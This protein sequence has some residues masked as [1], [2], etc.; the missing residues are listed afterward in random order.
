MALLL[1]HQYDALWSYSFGGLRSKVDL[2]MQ[3]V[4][5]LRL[6]LSL[7]LERER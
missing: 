3:I 2:Q 1:W 5:N 4:I 7:V 6:Q